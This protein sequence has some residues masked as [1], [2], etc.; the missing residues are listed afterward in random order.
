MVASRSPEGE[1]VLSPELQAADGVSKGV[2][3]QQREEKRDGELEGGRQPKLDARQ[4]EQVARAHDRLEGREVNIRADSHRRAHVV[5][6]GPDRDEHED[7]RANDD[8][9]Q[10]REQAAQRKKDAPDEKPLGGAVAQSL[11][12]KPTPDSVLVCCAPTVPCELDEALKDGLHG[13]YLA[14][15]PQHDADGVIAV[16]R[17][18]KLEQGF[19]VT[20]HAELA[21]LLG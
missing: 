19:V 17:A 21:L 7:E 9:T 16:L 12:L 13:E 8:V 3:A 11:V 20:L 1:R 18:Q 15:L 6:G 14:L 10:Q 2:R 5:D 4:V